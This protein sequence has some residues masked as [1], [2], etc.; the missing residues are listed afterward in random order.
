MKFYVICL[1]PILLT[2][3]NASGQQ[4]DVTGKYSR[5]EYPT[6]YIILNKDSSFI[7]RFNFDLNWDLACGTYKVNNSQIVFTY[8]SDMNDTLNCN[9]EGIGILPW[10]KKDEGFTGTIDTRYRP[11][12]LYISG[13]KLYLSGDGGRNRKYY[14]KK[15]IKP[16]VKKIK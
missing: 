3:F 4:A 2:A 7:Y 14:F 11:D 8:T 12:S 16:D 5:S 9:I 13:K 15:E 1:F 10:R 6:S